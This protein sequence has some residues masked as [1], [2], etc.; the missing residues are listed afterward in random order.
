MKRPLA[1][2]LVWCTVGGGVAAEQKRGASTHHYVCFCTAEPEEENSEDKGVRTFYRCF[3]T[4]CQQI[5][6]NN[7]YFIIKQNE[8]KSFCVVLVERARN[9]TIDVLFGR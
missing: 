3:K 5:I 8:E 7:K 6:T 2:R 9:W 1:A 4:L